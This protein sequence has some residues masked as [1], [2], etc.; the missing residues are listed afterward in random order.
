MAETDIIFLRNARFTATVGRDCWHRDKPQPVL[1]SVWLY[2]DTGVAERSDDVKDTINYGTLYK[3][4]D[5]GLSG[6]WSSTLNNVAC[7]VGDLALRESNSQKVRAAVVLP[8]ALLRVEGNDGGIEMRV[9]VLK[10]LGGLSSIE[11][12]TLFVKN[13]H[14]YCI[15]GV[16][17]HERG[18]KQLVIINLELP[19]SDT[20]SSSSIQEDDYQR[21]FVPLIEVCCSEDATIR[22]P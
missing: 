10:D 12:R 13:L 7:H 6:S 17:P 5:E 11:S 8:K 9:G 16:N 21:K 3:A 4:L 18:E 1:V 22:T 20:R 14:L 2:T 15:L 19:A